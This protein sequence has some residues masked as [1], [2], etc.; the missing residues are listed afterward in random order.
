MVDMPTLQLA[1][2][3]FAIVDPDSPI[4]LYH[5]IEQDLRQLILNGEIPAEV[6][7][8]AEKELGQAYG[9]GRHTMRMALSRLATDDL[10]SRRAGRGTYV[11]SRVARTQFFLD[12]GLIQQINEMGCQARVEVLDIFP[13]VIAEP[14]RAIPSDKIGAGCLHI[15]RLYYGDDEP[16][17]IQHVVVLNKHFPGLEKQ[18]FSQFGLYEILVREYNLPITHIKTIVT[19]RVAKESQAELLQMDEGDPLLCIT[20]LACLADRNCDFEYSDTYLRTDKYFF[21]IMED[22][23]L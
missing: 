15:N 21:T 4:P 22:F 23:R 8:P 12:R 13:S 11:K 17:G 9:V 5:Q 6:F 16:L 19:A 2:I 3:P 18:D 1:D 10:I 7:L 20:T 14:T